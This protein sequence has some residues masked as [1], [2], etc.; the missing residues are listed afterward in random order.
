MC[1]SELLPPKAAAQV[2]GSSKERER[3]RGRT[4]EGRAEAEAVPLL[5]S[6]HLSGFRAEQRDAGE[7]TFSLLVGSA[8]HLLLI[9]A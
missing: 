7:G 8:P 9:E 5:F 4:E 3:R 2:A 6:G 1:R